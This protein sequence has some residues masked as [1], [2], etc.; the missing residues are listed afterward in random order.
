MMEAMA[1]NYKGDFILGKVAMIDELSGRE[2]YLLSYTAKDLPVPYE[3]SVATHG[4]FFPR[5]AKGVRALIVFIV[6]EDNDEAMD[7]RA[8]RVSEDGQVLEAVRNF[9]SPDVDWQTL[10]VWQEHYDRAEAMIDDA[11][12]RGHILLC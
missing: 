4:K 11:I 9:W 12:K 1:K 6:D 10:C 7:V 2:Y 3:G 8:E 5:D